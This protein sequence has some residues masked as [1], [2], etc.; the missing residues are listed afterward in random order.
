MNNIY[1]DTKH[2]VYWLS[3]EWFDLKGI[4]QN[5]YTCWCKRGVSKR[6]YIDGRAY[7]NYDTIPLESREKL[8]DKEGLKKEYN[9]QKTELKEQWCFYRLEPVYKKSDRFPEYVNAILKDGRYNKLKREQVNYFARRACVI[10]KAIELHGMHKEKGWLTGLYYAYSRLYPDDYSMKNRFCMMLKKAREEGVLSVAIDKRSLR[11]FTP[12]YTEEYQYMA[13]EILSDPRAFD[14]VMCHEK[15]QTACEKQQMETPS[16]WWIRDYYRKNKNFINITRH[17]K[18]V[19]EKEQR[20]YANIIPALHRN[21][22]WQIDG[23][24]IPIYG[25]RQRE[26]GSWELYFKYVF[27]AVLDA[28]SRKYVGYSIGESENTE[29]IL[30]ALENAVKNTGVLP[31][32]IVSDNHSFNQTKEAEHFKAA[33]DKIGVHWTVDSN[34]RR[35]AILE[36]SFRTLSEKHLKNHYGYIGA[37]IRSK[38]KG[39]R[40]P[41]ELIDE[42]TKNS[43]RFPNY[44]TIAISVIDSVLEYNDKV[45][46]KFKQSPNERYENSE[47]PKCFEVDVFKR[48]QLFTRKTEQKITNGQFTIKRGEYEYSYQL[49]AEF[50]TRYNGETVTL[51]YA[52]FGTMYLYDYATDAPICSVLQKSDIYGAMGDQTDADIHKLHKNTGRL[53]G[54]ESKSRKRKN[55]IFDQ[56]DTINPNAADA[57]NKVKAPKEVVKQIEQNLHLREIALNQGVKPERVTDAPALG[58]LTVSAPEREENNH[59]FSVKT[60]EI[61]KISIEELAES[62]SFRQ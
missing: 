26:D 38:K 23:W 17:G 44:D 48:M 27:F 60:S 49:P 34:P 22:Q 35:K 51:R 56:C 2:Q 7:I 46:P 19:Y 20:P 41:Q 14:T 52:D 10:E 54:I 9:R 12:K 43:S 39:S 21:T 31:Y 29:V 5:T 18:E 47:Q 42:Y 16:V 28:H 6:K 50:S 62:M 24:E 40:M 36:R 30:K 55:T 59:P 53:K 15:M 57:I 8:P 11:E 45:K 32:E 4:S 37:G 1:V 58:M 25:K 3:Y 13:H 61:C 33:L